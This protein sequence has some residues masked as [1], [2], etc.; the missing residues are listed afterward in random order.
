MSHSDTHV[1]RHTARSP[2][3][4]VPDS[5]HVM[6]ACD[7][8]PIHNYSAQISDNHRDLTKFQILPYIFLQKGLV[9]SKIK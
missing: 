8:C 4:N 3:H 2:T 7:K 6:Y 9:K 5:M 1:D